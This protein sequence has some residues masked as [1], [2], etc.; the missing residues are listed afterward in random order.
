M[1]TEIETTFSETGAAGV[2]KIEA[3]GCQHVIRIGDRQPGIDRAVHFGKYPPLL[4]R[5]GCRDA[6]FGNEHAVLSE[7][8]NG[9]PEGVLEPASARMRP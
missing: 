2:G 6:R 4:D 7:P 3:D 5:F 8:E 1:R 9:D